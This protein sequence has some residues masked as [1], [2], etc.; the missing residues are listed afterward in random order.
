MERDFAAAGRASVDPEQL[1]QALLNLLGNAVEATEQGAIRLEARSPEEGWVEIAVE[2]TG[3]G[4]SEADLE[5]IFDLYY[6]TKPEGTGVGL[7]M[8]QRIVA[9]HGGRVAVRSAVDAGTRFTMRLPR[10]KDDGERDDS[11]DR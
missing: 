10:G 3:P 1:E 4:I 11:G 8:V 5:R 6:T 7:S 9:E 2:D